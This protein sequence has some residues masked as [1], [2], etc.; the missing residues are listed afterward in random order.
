MS[1]PT[2]PSMKTIQI[3]CRGADLVPIERLAA[4]QGNLKTLAK[5]EYEKLSRLIEKHGF[6]FPVAVWRRGHAHHIIDGHQRVA[7]TK[8]MLEDGYSLVGGKLPVDWIEA[9]SAAEAKKKVLMAASQFGRYTKESVD[10]FLEE[11]SL[12]WDDLKME[13]DLPGLDMKSLNGGAPTESAKNVSG[14]L[15][16]KILI[17]CKSEKHQRELLTEFEK[18]DI[19]CQALMF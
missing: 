14:D 12:S 6:S 7:T 18:R 2:S 17:V 3:T 5:T 10:A 13:I 4:F 8:K 9:K 16:F 19:E 1:D 11:S 15:E